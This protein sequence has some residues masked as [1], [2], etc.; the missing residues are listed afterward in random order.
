MPFLP[1]E[2]HETAQIGMD[3]KQSETVYIHFLV[4]DSGSGIST[5]DQAA[6][7]TRF[8][9]GSAKDYSQYQGSGLGLYISRA[10]VEIHAGQMGFKSVVGQGSTF[11]FAIK[12][13]RLAPHGSDDSCADSNHV[14]EANVPSARP[15]FPSSTDDKSSKID[16]LE[17]SHSS[18]KRKNK[19]VLHIL[20]VEDNPINQKVLSK[21]L[22]KAG[23]VVEIANHGG[24]CLEIIAM[25]H[26]CQN[27]GKPLSLVLMDVE[28]PVMNGIECTETIRRM[29]M[30]GRIKSHVPIIATTGN[31]RN[32]KIELI[33]KA[34]V[35]RVVLKP[36]SVNDLLKII[37]EFL[38][39]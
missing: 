4:V 20:M 19:P 27:G 7:F 10:M 2:A 23:H 18:T 5:E 6:V 38:Q 16:K 31:A 21:Q 33:R 35:D 12:T 24:E 28:M 22:A 15:K 8:A 39:Q 25:S 36:Y 13:R 14:P 17:S 9:Q 1:T 37:E 26:F 11:G 34:G 32:E 29:T 30:D 3:W